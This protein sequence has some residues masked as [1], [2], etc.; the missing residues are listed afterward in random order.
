MPWCVGIDEAGYGPNL[1]PLV[2]AAVAM[3]LPEGDPAGWET[4]R[5]FGRRI[6][7]SEPG[8]IPIDDSKKVYAGVNGFEKLEAGVLGWF[9]GH[10]PGC[11]HMVGDEP[12]ILAESFGDGFGHPL[13][14]PASRIA[15]NYVTPASFNPVVERHGSKG[16]VLGLGVV[17]LLRSIV[18]QLPEDGEAVHVHADKQGGRHFYGPLLQDA[19]EHGFV[20]AEK[21]GPLESRYRVLELGREVVVRFTPRADGS[22][23]AAALASM[24]CKY[25]RELGMREFND[26]WGSHVPGLKPT[27]GY[28]EDAKRYYAAIRETMVKLK[29]E[30]DTVWR[31]K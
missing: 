8:C 1:G 16:T 7:E 29:I 22:S 3:Q 2:Q 13:P 12:E 14:R 4:I 31:R 9:G 30:P 5:P 23:A 25:L 20:V 10:W 6:H 21:E 19:F 17:A 24:V 18:G 28:P 15:V 11:V 27:A 26:F